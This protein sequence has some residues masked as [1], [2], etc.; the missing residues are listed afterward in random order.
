MKLYKITLSAL[1]ALSFAACSNNAETTEETAPAEMHEDMD[2]HEGHDHSPDATVN[3]ED[4]FVPA[5][6]K[7]FFANLKD[8]DTVKS[9]VKVVF[10]IEGMEVKAAG[11]NERGTGH[12]HIIIDGG[13]LNPGAVVPADETNIHFGGGQTET[14]LKLTPGMH[15]L[16]LQ[17]ANGL[18]ASYGPQMSATINVFVK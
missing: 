3:T 9:P 15:S 17:F 4:L 2:G 7:V 12:H 8:G 18:H 13:A 10:G 14:E 16:T 1:I 6:G 5:G 11:Q